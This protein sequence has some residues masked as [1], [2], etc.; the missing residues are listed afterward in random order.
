[1]PKGTPKK[2]RSASRG[3]PAK[4]AEPATSTP[5]KSPAKPVV[6]P[7]QFEMEF[8]EGNKVM[9]RLVNTFNCL[10]LFLDEGYTVLK[11]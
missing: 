4:A 11:N 5:A 9:A 10:V 1:M 2:G 6:A 7:A 8:D 3:R